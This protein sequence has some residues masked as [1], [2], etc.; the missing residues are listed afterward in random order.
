MAMIRWDL[1]ALHLIPPQV[2]QQ[3]SFSLL[4]ECIHKQ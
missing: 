2:K 4:D 3:I 1:F